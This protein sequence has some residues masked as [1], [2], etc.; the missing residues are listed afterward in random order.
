MQI[1]EIRDL[2]TDEPGKQLTLTW[3]PGQESGLKTKEL[4]FCTSSLMSCSRH[5]KNTSTYCKRVSVKL[6]EF[7]IMYFV[8]VLTALVARVIF[9]GFSQNL[10]KKCGLSQNCEAGIRSEEVSHTE[11]SS[12]LLDTCYLLKVKTPRLRR[13][14]STNRPKKICSS[15][16]PISLGKDCLVLTWTCRGLHRWQGRPTTTCHKALSTWRAPGE[17]DRRLPTA[18]QLGPGSS[19]ALTGSLL[20]WTTPRLSQLERLVGTTLASMYAS[21]S[22]H[23]LEGKQKSSPPLIDTWPLQCD[24]DPSPP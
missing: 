19:R 14:S 20:S 17:P 22:H 7:V 1:L 24:P 9:C 12:A 21:S 11:R 23:S 4:L 15:T 3:S 10:E 5:G 18:G 6:V 13:A 16:C 2:V 8:G